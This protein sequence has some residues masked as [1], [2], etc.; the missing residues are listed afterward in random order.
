V[1][2]CVPDL[3]PKPFFELQR[4]HTLVLKPGIYA[5]YSG[6]FESMSFERFERSAMKKAQAVAKTSKT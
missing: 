1:G 6:P 3:A 5:Q 4:K 2:G